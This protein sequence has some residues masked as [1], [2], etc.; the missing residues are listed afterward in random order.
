MIIG[1]SIFFI[2]ASI[3]LIAYRLI[4]GPEWSDRILGSELLAISLASS[5]LILQLDNFQ[6]WDR[7]AIW[8]LIMMGFIGSIGA[9]L[10]MEKKND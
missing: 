2:M 9:S 3:P 8:L 10:L 1:L 6:K 4:K 7:E 5:L